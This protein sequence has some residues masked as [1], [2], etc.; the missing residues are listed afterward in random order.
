MKT[1]LTDFEQGYL[2]G[3]EMSDTFCQMTGKMDCL[4][5]RI[6]AVQTY[7][8]FDELKL[9]NVQLEQTQSIL[10]GLLFISIIVATVF[11]TLAAH[12]KYKK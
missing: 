10:I 1:S 9:E 12:Y 2:T 4:E 8:E 7:Q 3:Q 11:A 6:I 5:E